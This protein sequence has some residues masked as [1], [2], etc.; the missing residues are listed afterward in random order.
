[1]CGF[2]GFV[3]N[4][5]KQKINIIEDMSKKIVHRGPDSFGFYTDDEIALGFRRLS[6]IDLNHSDQPIY[7]E[8]NSLV[9]IFNGEIYNFEEIRKELIACGHTF[10]TKGDTEVIIHGYE[11]YGQ[12]IVKKLRG[13][14]AFVIW[15]KAKNMLFGARDFFGI[16]PF[17]YAN[18]DGCFIF[19]SEIKSF[20][21]HPNFKKTLNKDA[22]KMY[23]VFQYSPLEETMFKDVFKLP[24]G[25]MFTYQ[26]GVFEKKQYFESNFNP[27]N[28]NFD[29]YIDEISKTVEQSVKAH[30][31][32]DV[33]VGSF[34][35]GGVDSSFVASIARPNH[36]YSVGFDGDGFDETIY[37]RE[38]SDILQIENKKHLISADDFFSAI[39]DVQYHSDEPHANL[40]AVPLFFLAKLASKDLKVVLS[41]EGAD[42]LFA[43]YNEYAE[44][45]YKS[46]YN[47]FPLTLRSFVGNIVKK[48]P[49]FKGK[50]FF[51]NNSKSIEDSYI[52]QAFI[53]GNHEANSYLNAKHKSKITF[54]DVTKPY[55]DNVKNASD[56]HKKM[57]LD[58]KLWLPNDILLKADKMTMASSLELRVPFLDKEL[59]SVAA[60]IPTQY[61]IN[62]HTTKWAFREAAKKVI[63]LDWAKRKKLG[64][65]VPFRDWICDGKYYNV[66]KQEFNQDFV[67]DIFDKQMLNILLDDHFTKKAQN[68]RK[69]YTIF[70]FLVWY[71][72]YFIKG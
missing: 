34:L 54:Q 30:Q 33:E 16:K 2:V 27:V 69:I 41:G 20:L 14:F 50:S 8:D 58:M 3:D 44:N 60:K 48:M 45:P 22:L 47:K 10:K 36:T 12:D 26:D 24:A 55:F 23:L 59:F 46:F 9:I 15:D 51:I 32:A 28:G 65:P 63:P 57:Y 35:S 68:G 52:G 39:E 67:D 25:Y 5:T 64:F 56:L 7:N 61:L 72:K 49:N 62:K 53:M 37:A 42:E 18:M 17:Y 19:G 6:I 21:P 13:M 71:K 40:S 43:G 4:K 66:V 31:I 70:A 29:D 1:M 38:L 11:E